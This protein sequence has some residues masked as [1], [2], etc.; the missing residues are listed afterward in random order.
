[1]L[2]HPQ[3]WVMCVGFV[4]ERSM[5]A[6]VV[7]LVAGLEHVGPEARCFFRRLL[8]FHSRSAEVE[9]EKLWRDPFAEHRVCR[10]H[11]NPHV[12][13]RCSAKKTIPF[14]ATSGWKTGGTGIG[15]LLILLR[16]Q[17]N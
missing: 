13:A 16:F 8:G 6:L 12:A 11:T 5:R 10:R 3:L 15:C 7:D 4:I 14:A 17:L 2:R 9:I 1:M